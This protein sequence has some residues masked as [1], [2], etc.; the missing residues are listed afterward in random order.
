MLK[1]QLIK[2]LV[3]LVERWGNITRERDKTFEGLYIEWLERKIVRKRVIEQNSH[4]AKRV[5]KRRE[6]EAW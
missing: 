4:C 3:E 2:G 1:V 5:I 6:R